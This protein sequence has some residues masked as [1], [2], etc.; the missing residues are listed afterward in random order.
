[1]RRRLG[2]RF[3]S[4]SAG[5]RG[6]EDPENRDRAGCRIQETRGQ[7]QPASPQAPAQRHRSTSPRSGIAVPIISHNSSRA[8]DVAGIGE[9]NGFSSHV[10]PALF[11]S[12]SYLCVFALTT[13]LG[14]DDVPEQMPS[15]TL[16]L[17]Q[18]ELLDR[19]KIGR[20]GLDR[21]ARQQAVQL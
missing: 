13:H 14:A 2:R 5:G 4:A 9:A 16:E 11:N 21:D 18:L 19:S 1:V 6:H 7:R 12:G 8:N 15:L 10:G 17:L 20:A 3:P